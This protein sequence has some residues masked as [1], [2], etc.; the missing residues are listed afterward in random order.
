MILVSTASVV[1]CGWHPDDQ[2]AVYKVLDQ[3][4]LASVE[5]S[6]NRHAGVITLRGVVGSAD[7]RAQAEQLTLQAAP[8][9]TVKNLL[10]IQS[11]LTVAPNSAGAATARAQ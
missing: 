4:N 6:Q 2:A 7:N 11:S 3:H 10:Q 1:G 9:Y 8:G 5:V